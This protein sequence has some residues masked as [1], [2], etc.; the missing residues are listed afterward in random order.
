LTCASTSVSSNASGKGGDMN[1]NTNV[2]VG[3]AGLVKDGGAGGNGGASPAHSVQSLQTLDVLVSPWPVEIVSVDLRGIRRL[4]RPFRS[5]S[6]HDLRLG[7]RLGAMGWAAG[8]G[9]GVPADQG[10]QG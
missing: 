5:T 9:G 3:G 4:R 10:V 7:V 2:A 6:L 8:M 1:S